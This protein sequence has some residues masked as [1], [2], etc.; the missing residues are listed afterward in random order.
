MG[1]PNQRENTKSNKRGKSTR[2][3]SQR[4]PTVERRVRCIIEYYPNPQPGHLALSIFDDVFENGEYKGTQALMYF[5]YGQKG[6]RTIGTDE[7]VYGASLPFGLGYQDD[8]DYDQIRKKFSAQ[9]VETNLLKGITTKPEVSDVKYCLLSNN[10]AHF[11]LNVLDGI[12]YKL[13]GY[14]KAKGAIGMTPSQAYGILKK[15]LSSQHSNK[16]LSLKEQLQTLLKPYH[17]TINTDA[18]SAALHSATHH[19]E[20]KFLTQLNSSQDMGKTQLYKLFLIY[21]PHLDSTLRKTIKTAIFE[22][23][24]FNFKK[25]ELEEIRLKRSII[26][27]QKK[28]K[29]LAFEG[30]K[31]IA[32]PLDDECKKLWE[33]VDGLGKDEVSSSNYQNKK[34]NISTVIESD[35]FKTAYQQAEKH[36]GFKQVLGNLALSLTIIGIPLVVA[37]VIS[38]KLGHGSILFRTNTQQR[39]DEFKEIAKENQKQEGDELYQSTFNDVIIPGLNA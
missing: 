12:G 34:R 39:L 8:A 3:K 28:A 31:M 27:V 18:E 38:T 13:S 11:I 37:D 17:C 19:A 33:A 6:P 35:K 21:G 32:K 24:V 9:M 4:A 36:R 14:S 20:A 23:K 1:G 16:E 7:N 26:G 5:S 2:G 15:S 10:C 22:D 29:Q 25:S 30:H